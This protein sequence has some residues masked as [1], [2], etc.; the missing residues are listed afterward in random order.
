MPPIIPDEYTEVVLEKLK[1]GIQGAISPHLIEAYVEYADLEGLIT[2]EIVYRVTGFV[3]SEGVQH[4]EIK[5]PADWWQ[6]FK[7][8]WFPPWLLKHYPVRYK[9]HVIDIKAIYPN[10]R[11]SIPKEDYRLIIQEFK[12]I[13]ELT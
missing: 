8:R 9:Y 13:N 6:A 7:E 5:Y 1:L 4:V 3:W 11:P 10:F 2:D 12:G